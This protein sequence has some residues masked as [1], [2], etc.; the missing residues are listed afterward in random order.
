[1]RQIFKRTGTFFLS[2]CLT[3][4]VW[5]ILTP[6]PTAAATS[7]EY[8]Y[9]INDDGT[10]KITKYT[11][12][13]GDVT[14]PGTLG[15]RTV[16]TIES[17]AFSGCIGL[18]SIDIPDSVTKIGDFAFSGCTRLTSVD[19][20][21][22]VTTIDSYAFS[23]CTRLTSVDIPD[24][25]TT[26]GMNAFY[27]CTGLASVDIPDSVTTIDSHAFSNCTGLT[28]VTI[29]DSVTE[30]GWSA[31]SDC[32]RLTSVTLPDSVTTI[33]DGAFSGCTKLTDVYYEGSLAE[34][35]NINILGS[36]GPLTNATI[37]TNSFAP[38]SSVSSRFSA[39]TD[40][41]SSNYE[42]KV[43]DD[44]TASI[45][46][47]L[48]SG[49]D[50]T[51]PDT[52]GDHT[53]TMIGN[54]AF[55]D[56]NRLTSVT[57]P[58]SVTE[59]GQYAFFGCTK[60]ISITIPDSVTKIGQYAFSGCTKL[61]D[62]YYGDSWMKWERIDIGTGNDPLIDADMYMEPN[63]LVLP[64]LIQLLPIILLAAI[65]VV[66]VLY[67]SGKGRK[68]KQNNSIIE[69][70]DNIIEQEDNNMDVYCSKC[71]ERLD[72]LGYCP[73]CDAETK[74]TEPI[75]LMELMEQAE[76]PAEEQTE[77]QTE[78]PTE[79]M[80]LLEQMRQTEQREQAEQAEKR[81]ESSRILG[82]SVS[83]STQ[84]LCLAAFPVLYLILLLSK[85]FTVAGTGYH[86]YNL[87]NLF[88]G[89]SSFDDLF[90]Y[91]LDDSLLE[92][93]TTAGWIV[94]VLMLGL[95]AIMLYFII[96]GCIMAVEQRKEAVDYIIKASV[97]AIIES[98][99]ALIVVAS[100]KIWFATNSYFEGLGSSIGR[101][102]DFTAV[103]I[104]LLIAGVIGIV[105]ARRVCQQQTN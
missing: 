84:Y 56:H 71:G 87:Y 100:L 18:T 7:G 101:R 85:W 10:A 99:F 77:E 83:I 14:I 60:L 42:Y 23:N 20:G 35:E 52:L 6:L 75:E 78:E 63:S 98:V 49:G 67:F 12:S 94:Y 57:I 29:P 1:M 79:L 37:H 93:I 15:D 68:K 5:G 86:I 97:T 55:N 46:K 38:S 13:G 36:D 72:E 25:V 39:A 2:L 65:V 54:S 31:F 96:R 102:I 81:K 91:I 47:Y 16:S 3:L 28:S 24:S 69:Q 19:I 88:D 61:S 48:G 40:T 64:I 90:S 80:K 26:I 95:S 43:K 44:G 62:V 76:Q 9:S 17:F 8:G 27:S 104:I 103:P 21:D 59:I 53:V 22:G 73:H 33:D 92:E 34:W 58:D 105:V 66:I 82:R 4:S 11:G 45:T 30:I 50:V 74:P 89:L 32:T 51:I 41:S 70:E